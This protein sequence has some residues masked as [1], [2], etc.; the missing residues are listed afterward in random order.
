MRRIKS[1]TWPGLALL[2]LLAVSGT[3]SSQTTT[4]G[5]G[6]GGGGAASAK[7]FKDWVHTCEKIEGF[8]QEQCYI[9]QN[10]ALKKTGKR[11]LHFAVGYVGEG[12]AKRPAAVITLPLG[13]LLPPG[14]ALRIDE[15]EPIR[16]VYQQCMPDGCRGVL[17]L[18]PA[19]ISSLKA[20]K[21]A[22]ITFYDQTQRELGVPVSLIG[23]TAGFGALKP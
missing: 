10:I 19:T 5:G 15:G 23:F 3:S 16:F 11:L 9:F 20:G 8:G 7:T 21:Q 2:A 12:D 13:V 14:L 1:V 18:E 17:P 6:Q 22:R 4:Q